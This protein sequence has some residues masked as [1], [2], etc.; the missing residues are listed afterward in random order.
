MIPFFSMLKALKLQATIDLVNFKKE[1]KGSQNCAVSLN[2]VLEIVDFKIFGL[3][4]F[5][6]NSPLSLKFI[7]V[8]EID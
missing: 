1:G 3:S 5:F 7:K 2:Q 8:L 4:H 6:V